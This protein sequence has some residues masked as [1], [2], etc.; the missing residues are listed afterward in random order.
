MP[1]GLKPWKKKVDSVLCLQPPNKVKQVQSFL[2]LVT[3][4]CDMFPWWSHQ[5]ALLTELTCKGHITWTLCHTK[6]F[7]IMKAMMIYD[8][9][10]RYPDHNKPFQIY[11]DASDYQ[12]RSVIMQNGKPVAYYSHKL[13]SA[14]KHYTTMEKELLSVVE[15]FKEFHTMLLGARITVYTNH[16][17]NMFHN[18]KSQRW[19]MR[20]R[21]FLE[22]YSPKF[23]YILGPLNVIVDAF[24]WL[25]RQPSTKY[26]GFRFAKPKYW[27]QRF[28][29]SV[30]WQWHVRLLPESWW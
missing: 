28:L 8:C 5:L 23:V 15:T 19:V 12:L 11:T 6:A 18:L 14:Q 10:L 13:N 3:Y 9:L 20:W 7:E 22:E 17:K 16:K 26:H 4:Y 24:L 30:W 29:F 25:P 2:G 27:I 21:S 1:D